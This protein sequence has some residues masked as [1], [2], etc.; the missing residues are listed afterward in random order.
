MLRRKTVKEAGKDMLVFV[1]LDVDDGDVFLAQSVDYIAISS[2]AKSAL[3]AR[4]GGENKRLSRFFGDFEFRGDDGWEHG[5]FSFKEEKIENG[6]RVRVLREEDQFYIK[7]SHGSKLAIIDYMPPADNE[8]LKAIDLTE[9]ISESLLWKMHFDAMKARG[10]EPSC[11]AQ[12]IKKT[13]PN[14]LTEKQK[15]LIKEDYRRR[16]DEFDDYNRH[17]NE[18]FIDDIITG[19]LMNIYLKS[20]HVIKEIAGIN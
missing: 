15:E 1:S 3:R 17:H 9:R 10:E 14:F 12:T 2:E 18:E 20:G 5:W 8:Y 16:C 4:F 13:P 6:V 7:I 19:E 11:D